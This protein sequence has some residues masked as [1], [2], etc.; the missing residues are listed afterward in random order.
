VGFSKRPTKGPSTTLKL[1]LVLMVVF[2]FIA[3]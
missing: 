2:S 3:L 1:G